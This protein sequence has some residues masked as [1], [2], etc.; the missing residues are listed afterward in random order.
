MSAKELVDE[1]FNYGPLTE[2]ISRRRPP[3]D[4][5]E[6]HTDSPHSAVKHPRLLHLPTTN[7][8]LDWTGLES[9]VNDW[10]EPVQKQILEMFV[11]SNGPMAVAKRI[12]EDLEMRRS[13]AKIPAKS[14]SDSISYAY[15]TTFE[16][17]ACVWLKISFEDK[18]VL[19]VGSA[20][21]LARQISRATGSFISADGFIFE[22]RQNQ[23][24]LESVCEYKT[25]PSDPI[26]LA[27]LKTQIENMTNFLTNFRNQILSDGQ[28]HKFDLNKWEGWVVRKIK[29]SNTPSII[30]VIPQDRDY[31]VDN[32][33]VRVLKAPFG[34]RQLSKVVLTLLR[35]INKA[36]F[37]DQE[38]ALLEERQQLETP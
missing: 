27:A 12:K 15:G 8:T 22:R 7:P 9:L 14:V 38:L 29:V 5:Q 10:N 24:I 19:D 13:R 17:L 31:L 30:L 16:R 6:P 36:G 32:E 25:N 33:L 1:E 26:S 18:K 23:A 2:K 37:F 20:N 35:D 11:V 21:V 4:D 34:P 28:N 3:W